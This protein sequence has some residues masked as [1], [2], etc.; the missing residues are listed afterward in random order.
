[1][2][3]TMRNNEIS[4]SSIEEMKIREAVQNSKFYD[5]NG[6]YDR[7][8]ADELV[9]KRL[10]DQPDN[11]KNEKLFLNGWKKIEKERSF[12]DNLDK[13]N[14]NR[15]KGR[16]WLINCQRCVPTYEMR[17]RGYDVTALP[18]MDE[19][20]YDHLAY[21]PFDVWE[22]PEVIRC[23]DSGKKDIENIMSEWE[24]GS[25]AQIVVL[26]KGTNSGHTFTAEKINGEIKYYDPQTCKENVSDYFRYVEPGS[27]RFCRID[28][29][30]VSHRIKECCKEV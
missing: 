11:F 7:A 10:T 26:W 28:N 2:K 19:F 24:D 9:E 5:I 18:R 20:G 25:R 17:R 1:M 3:E 8:K 14:P 29:L 27:T 16:E 4:E 13:V 23:S 15:D 22:S 12:L 21:N 30:D 6:K